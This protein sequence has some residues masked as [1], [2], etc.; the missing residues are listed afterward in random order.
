[1]ENLP[2]T[3]FLRIKDVLKFIPV[4]KS[5]WWQGVKDG[6]YPAAV[7]LGARCVAW[8]AEDI[9]TLI[10]DLNNAGQLPPTKTKTP[11][12]NRAVA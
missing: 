2:N 8:R 1:M 11:K 3:G 10:E 7:K 12:S 9:R 6:R 4:G 5:T